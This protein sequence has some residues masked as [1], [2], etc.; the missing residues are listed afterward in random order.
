M[1]EA[2]AASSELVPVGF[3]IMDVMESF[4]LASWPRFEDG[5]T[6]CR[7]TPT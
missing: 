2:T 6:M 5:L 7:S 1:C 4:P 3:E